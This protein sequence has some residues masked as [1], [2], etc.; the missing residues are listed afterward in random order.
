M[1]SWE[2]VALEITISRFRFKSKHLHRC[3]DL[4]N[5]SDDADFKRKEKY[6]PGLNCIWQS[7]GQAGLFTTWRLPNNSFTRSPE[8]PHKLPCGAKWVRNGES[9]TN[10]G[11]WDGAWWRCWPGPG[12]RRGGFIWH[13]GG[14]QSRVTKSCQLADSTSVGARP[15]GG[16]QPCASLSPLDIAD[17]QLCN[18]QRLP[19]SRVWSCLVKVYRLK[20]VEEEEV[21]WEMYLRELQEEDF[22]IAIKVELLSYNPIWPYSPLTFALQRHWRLLKFSSWPSR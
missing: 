11:R 16:S 20:E 13:G 5:S 4:V 2:S 6:L 8:I 3:Q 10:A 14:E 21:K 9:V 1:W 22:E 12:R 7:W 15:P 19:F 17:F 18:E